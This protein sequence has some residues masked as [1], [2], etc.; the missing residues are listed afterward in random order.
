MAR[1]NKAPLIAALKD[2]SRGADKALD[3]MLI[4]Y[5]PVWEFTT[6]E[7]E[8]IADMLLKRA[9]QSEIGAA[10]VMQIMGFGEYWN[11]GAIFVPRITQTLVQT[12]Q[13]RA[14][15]RARVGQH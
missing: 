11:L 10:L 8:K 5:I 4:G 15:R 12:A 3:K 2:M 14:R 6:E 9:Q 1:E 7:A 13:S